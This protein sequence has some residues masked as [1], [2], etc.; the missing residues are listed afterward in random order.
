MRE[1]FLGGSIVKKLP[2]NAEDT[3]VRSLDWKDLLEK[4]MVTTPF[5][6]SWNSDKQRSL[7]GYS[8]WSHKR[9]GHDLASK[10]AE[11]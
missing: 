1:S 3:G 2:A 5:F 4:E 7:A 9:V 8:P 6:L 10:T 11:G